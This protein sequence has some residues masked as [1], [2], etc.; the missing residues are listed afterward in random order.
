MKKDLTIS[1]FLTIILLPVINFLVEKPEQELEIQEIKIEEIIPIIKMEYGIAVDSF[2]VEDKEITPN[3]YLAEL[4]MQCD[5]SQKNISKII[6]KTKPVFD[7]RKIKRGNKYKVFRTNDTLQTVSYIV[8]HKNLK[9]YIVFDFTDTMNVYSG[10]KKVVKELVTGSGEIYSNLWETMQ[11]NDI[12]PLIA[13]ELSDIYAWSIDFFGL[14]NGD[15]F[16]IIYEKQFI[17][18]EEFGLGKIKVA[19]FEHFGK[20]IYAIPFF[21]DSLTSYYN[22]DGTSLRKAFLKAPL[23]YSRISSGFSNSRLHPILKIRRP[24]HGID[25]AA[26]AGTPVQTIGDGVVIEAR[27]SSSAGNILK[28]KHN[29]VYTT[30]YLHLSKFSEGIKIGSHVKQGEVIGFVGSTG[31]ST[32][33]HLDF[34]V[35]KNGQAI[36]PLHVDAPP[37][38]PVKAENILDFIKVRDMYKTQLDEIQ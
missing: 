2:T 15:K 7:V 30:G 18:G 25:Y 23:S 37:V 3:L 5:I 19:Y 4:F 22:V 16:K 31:L 26:P 9:N 34:R 12:N 27:Y 32:G 6:Q 35:W 1:I 13:N 38:E 8:Y 10:E 21:Q 14:Q 24:H 36:D 28:I 17:D 11:E 33:A 29:G 20:Q